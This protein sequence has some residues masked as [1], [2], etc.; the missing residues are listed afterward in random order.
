MTDKSI[1]F[2]EYSSYDL[3]NLG[4]YKSCSDHETCLHYMFV[5]GIDIYKQL[6]VYSNIPDQIE[7]DRIEM[8][9]SGNNLIK[10]QL[11]NDTVINNLSIE[12]NSDN[13]SVINSILLHLR[14]YLFSD[15]DLLLNDI[16]KIMDDIKYTLIFQRVYMRDLDSQL[17]FLMSSNTRTHIKTKVQA[18]I[19]G[20]MLDVKNDYIDTILR[21]EINNYRS[22]Y[23]NDNTKVTLDN[24]NNIYTN[25]LSTFKQK[26]IFNI[27]SDTVSRIVSSITVEHNMIVNNSKLD[28]WDT[29]LGDQNKHGIRQFTN[30][31]LNNKK[32]PGMM[33]NM[34]Y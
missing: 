5:N 29:V 7:R 20:L 12:T 1:L 30:I 19:K 22:R 4:T 8:V 2:N 34:T 26:D 14:P 18:H 33:F 13:D 32:P 16:Q 15:R 23:R 9:L 6:D 25:G 21:T 27:I 10:T 24:V 31:K 11:L 17:K 28:K 3:N